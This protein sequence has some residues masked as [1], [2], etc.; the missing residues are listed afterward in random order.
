MP[1]ALALA[2]LCALSSNATTSAPPDNSA[3]ALISPEPPRPNTATLLPA[4]AVIGITTRL[5]QLQRRKACERQHHRD[6][7]ETNDDL[8][9]GPAEL[10]EMMVDRRHLEDALAGELERHHLDDHRHRLEHEQAADHGE[11][12]LVLGGHRDGADHAAERQRAGVA[13][14]DR[15][16]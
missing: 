3:P 1:A 9:L 7:P 13:H 14:E 2:M 4:K 5:P 8:R 6:D 10:L 11:N 12:D 15:G 16:R